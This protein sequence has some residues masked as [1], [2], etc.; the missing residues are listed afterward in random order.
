MA[1]SRQTYDFVGNRITEYKNR[2][3]EK[4]LIW[5][6]MEKLNGFVDQSDPDISIPNLYHLFQTAEG[7]RKDVLSEWM[8]VTG[9]LHDLGKVM[10]LWGS[11]ETGTTI[12][13]QWAIVGDTFITGC[14]LPDSLVHSEFNDLNPDS[15]HGVY[16]TKYGIYRPNIGLENCR[17]SWGHDEYLYRVLRDNNVDLPKDSLYIIRFHSLYAWHDK[18]EYTHLMNQYDHQMLPYVKQFNKYDLYTKTDIKKED[19]PKYYASLR[20]Y[21]EKLVSKYLGDSLLF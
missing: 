21:Y 5:D 20:P 18:G 8:Q 7:M 13:S 2:P 17:C 1:R 10:Y 19:L 12:D 15:H 11:N 3:K 9:L 14:E 6:A 16:S 4:M